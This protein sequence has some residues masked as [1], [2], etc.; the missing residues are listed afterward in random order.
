V[1]LKENS[2]S[3]GCLF[4][5]RMLNGE[6]ILFWISMSAPGTKHTKGVKVMHHN[7]AMNLAI[8]KRGLGRA[9][10]ARPLWRRYVASHP[11]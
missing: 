6:C 7:N 2:Q 1:L 10:S 8:E 11:A 4:V 5:L 9:N 3:F